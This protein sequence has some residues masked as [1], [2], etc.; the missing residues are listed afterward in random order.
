MNMLF[1]S[2]PGMLYGPQHPVVILLDLPYRNGNQ[3]IGR[4]GNSRFFSSRAAAPFSASAFVRRRF[5]ISESSGLPAKTI[6]FL[7]VKIGKKRRTA[8]SS[9]LPC[10]SFLWFFG[11]APRTRSARGGAAFFT[12]PPCAA[13]RRCRRL[14]C[15]ARPAGR[16]DAAF[17]PP[18]RACQQGLQD[19][20]PGSGAA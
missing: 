2:A 16:T 3:L 8:P 7:P 14:G 20:L 17:R 6:R 12:A 15:G 4:N 18:R 19:T 1:K 13:D 11:R 9:W 10:S 5:K